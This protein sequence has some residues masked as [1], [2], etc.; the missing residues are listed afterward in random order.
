M[1]RTIG[2][3]LI[4]AQR[5]NSINVPL[6]NDGPPSVSSKPAHSEETCVTLLEGL[7]VPSLGMCKRQPFFISQSFNIVFYSK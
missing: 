3:L 6:S 7:P 5:V 1:V 4:A 2:P